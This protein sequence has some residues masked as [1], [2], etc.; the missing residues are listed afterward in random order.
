MAT[1][2]FFQVTPQDLASLIREEIK[3]EIQGFILELNPKTNDGQ[4]LLSIEKT[5]E[6]FHVSKPTI[7]KWANEGIIRRYSMGNRTYFVK[8]ELMGD[9]LN[10]RKSA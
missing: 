7:H 4:E 8:A 9:L 5:A 2:Q 1:L 3:K 10:Q 6:F